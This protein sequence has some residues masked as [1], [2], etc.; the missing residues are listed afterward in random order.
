MTGVKVCIISGISGAVG[1]VIAV[2][3]RENTKIYG[4][5]SHHC[6]IWVDPLKS[7]RAIFV[8][9]FLSLELVIKCISPASFCL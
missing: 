3:W 6:G 9:S 4:S 1:Q 8:T 2:S 7:V 5:F